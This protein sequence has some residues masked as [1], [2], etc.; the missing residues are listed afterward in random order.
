MANDLNGPFT[1][2]DAW[3]ANKPMKRCSAS[4][5]IREMQIHYHQSSIRMV[6]MN[7]ADHIKCW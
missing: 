2:E 3:M 1:K 6:K 7:K 4:F 5:A